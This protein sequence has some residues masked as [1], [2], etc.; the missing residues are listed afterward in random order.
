MVISLDI[1]KAFDHANHTKIKKFIMRDTPVII[2]LVKSFLS[3]RKIIFKQKDIEIVEVSGQRLF[4]VPLRSAF[5]GWM[6]RVVTIKKT[7][8]DR[9]QNQN[10][11]KK[12]IRAKNV[13]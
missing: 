9:K 7:F 12:I 5:V 3:N 8:I 11:E 13:S 4:V 1:T 10:I 6:S 2:K